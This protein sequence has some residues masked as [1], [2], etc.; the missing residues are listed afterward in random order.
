VCFLLFLLHTGSVGASNAQT[1]ASV[2]NA[3]QIQVLNFVYSKIAT[4]LTDR[5]N[6]RTETMYE[7]SIIVKIFVFQFVNSYASF[8]YLAF[9]AEAFGDCPSDG[10]MSTLAINLAI[11]FGSRLV[12]G[13]IV[14]LLIPY[15]LFQFKYRDVMKKTKEIGEMSRPE[16]EFLLDPVMSCFDSIE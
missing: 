10:C 8:F 15:V 13:N 3:V 5:E 1:V 14:E 9:V 6:H 4:A 12:S 11:I 2:L 16:K 7:D